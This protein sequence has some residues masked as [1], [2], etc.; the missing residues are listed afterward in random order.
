VHD[1]HN[2]AYILLSACTRLYII[3]ARTSLKARIQNGCFGLRIAGTWPYAFSNFFEASHIMALKNS[4]AFL[5]LVL[6]VA[7]QWVCAAAQNKSVEHE[8]CQ[9]KCAEAESTGAASKVAHLPDASPV[10]EFELGIGD[11]L[12]VSVWREPELT[13][14]AVVRPDGKISI[15][16]AGEVE[17]EGKSAAD[18]QLVIRSRLL[19]Y[20]TDPRVTVSIVEIHSRQVFITG[21]VQRPGA[22]PLIGDFNVLQLIASAGGLT[23]YA[24]KKSIIILDAHNRPVF[25]FN[26]S[27]AVKGNPKQA[28]VLRAGETVV[29]P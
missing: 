6:V 15:P 18:A 28:T 27:S 22:Y 5:A 16:L 26:Y 2:F 14:T 11:V 9:G 1:A 8:E 13:E 24:H 20:V 19:K 23:P 21:Q 3:A 29:V 17:V 4:G 7:T 10:D 12:H 25:R